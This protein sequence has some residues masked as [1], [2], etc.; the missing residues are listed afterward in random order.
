MGINK[1]NELHKNNF[2]F[3]LCK[4]KKYWKSGDNE[5][6]NKYMGICN[7]IKDIRINKIG[8]TKI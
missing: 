7:S 1:E 5:S 3:Y 2:I 8:E 4:A 6:L